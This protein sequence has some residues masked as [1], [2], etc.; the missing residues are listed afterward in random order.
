VRKTVVRSFSIPPK[1][2]KEL[3]KTA[4]EESRTYS[5]LVREAIRQY[6]KNKHLDEIHMQTLMRG[7]RAVSRTSAEA[8]NGDDD[9]QE[10][11]RRRAVAA[12]AAKARRRS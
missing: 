4:E 2:L 9:E 12:P 10:R 5:E 7:G 8:E 3:E 6:L 1:L 11:P